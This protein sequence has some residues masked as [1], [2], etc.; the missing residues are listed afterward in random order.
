MYENSPVVLESYI[1][2]PTKYYNLNAGTITSRI[3]Q[4]GE[5]CVKQSK[6]YKKL[7]KSTILFKNL[8]SKN[9][10]SFTKPQKGKIQGTTEPAAKTAKYLLN[11]MLE[12]CCPYIWFTVEKLEDIGSEP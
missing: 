8:A 9:I 1:A 10:K 12:T 3:K 11:Q 5:D 4:E 6:F 2:N 7:Y